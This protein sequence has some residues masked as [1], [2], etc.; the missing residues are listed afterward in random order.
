ML[1]QLEEGV[2]M[3]L[4]QSNTFKGCPQGILGGLPAIDGGPAQVS[5]TI[6]KGLEAL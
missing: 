1:P 5:Q 2:E 6:A 4:D 3:A